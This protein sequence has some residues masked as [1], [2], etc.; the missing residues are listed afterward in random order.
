M[1]TTQ[2]LPAPDLD[3]EEYSVDYLNEVFG[4][5]NFE[6]RIQRLYDFFEEKDVLMT[7]S[8]GASAAFMLRLVSDNRPN[9]P[10]HF[11][12]TTYHF[13][14]TI[15]YK[16]ELTKLYNLNVVEVLPDPTQNALTRDEEWWKD[17]PKMCCSI[18]KVV[19]LDPI[20][21]D[22]K[23]WISG[24]MS[25]Q[26]DF[27]SHLRIFEQQGDIIKFHPLIDLS[28]GDYLYWSSLYKLPKHPLESQGYGSIGCTHCTQKG[29]GREGRW[30]GTG[31]TECGLH[32]GFFV[33]KQKAS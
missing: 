13:P 6:E 26:T 10:I 8:F 27:R 9:Q 18:N 28:E 19:P 23:V 4:P 24:L 14:E 2:A 16:E 21:A 11:I 30:A 12:D 7:S 25:Y 31:K 5:L 15:A 3:V 33:N 22:H 20:K 1:T 17:H 32:P 29:K